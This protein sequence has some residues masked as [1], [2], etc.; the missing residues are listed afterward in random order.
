MR[1]LQTPVRLGD[2]Q[3]IAAA[4]YSSKTKPSLVVAHL[5]SWSYHTTA[6]VGLFVLQDVAIS[7]TGTA[8]LY[9]FPQQPDGPKS[10][11]APNQIAFPGPKTQAGNQRGNAG[12]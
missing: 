8:Q 5:G 12:A 10:F 9:S 3:E 7:S 6:T 2:N 11:A 1:Q 4:K